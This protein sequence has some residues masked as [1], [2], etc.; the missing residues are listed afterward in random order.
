MNIN[1][2]EKEVS[3]RQL[4]GAKNWKAGSA[5]IIVL[6]S[7]SGMKQAA[8]RIV[9]MSLRQIK[10][11]IRTATTTTATTATTMTTKTTTTM[12]RITLFF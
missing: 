3:Y 11:T 2:R 8:A 6:F 12:R 1:Q 7:V 5:I 10:T 4:F 9:K